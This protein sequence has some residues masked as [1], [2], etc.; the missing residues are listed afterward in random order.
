MRTIGLL[1]LTTIGC[2]APAPR[3]SVIATATGAAPRLPAHVVAA[4]GVRLTL[5]DHPEVVVARPQAHLPLLVEGIDPANDAA[6]SRILVRT[7]G[8]LEVSGVVRRDDLAVRVCQAGPLDDLPLLRVRPGAEVRQLG[9]VTARFGVP[10]F[11][12]VVTSRVG[13]AFVFAAVDDDLLVEGWTSADAL[14]LLD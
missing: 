13:R 11:A 5:A 1:V 4:A 12:R 2:A 6:K 9:T 3:G 8:P 7:T 10:G 14:E